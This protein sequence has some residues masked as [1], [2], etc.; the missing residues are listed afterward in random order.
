MEEVNCLICGC[1]RR[2]VVYKGKDRLLELP[3]E[4]LLVRCANCGLVYLS[5]RPTLKEIDRYYP[6]EYEPYAVRSKLSSPLHRW[7]INYGIR[8]RCLP[9]VRRKEGGRVLDIG[10]AI[11]LFLNGMRRYGWQVQG[12]ETNPTAARYAQQ[13]LGLDV[14][15]G[16]LKEAN[17][18]NQYFDAVTMWDVLEHLHDPMTTL[19]EMH[20]VL[21]DDGLLLLRVPNLDSL[22][23]HLFGRYWAGLDVPR[24]MAVFS[25]QTLRQLLN[26]AGFN[27]LRAW[28]LSGSYPVFVLSLR[29]FFKEWVMN[30]RWRDALARVMESWPARLAS[31]PL[32][33]LLDRLNQGPLITVLAEK[34]RQKHA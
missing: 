23:A 19:R 24:H 11:G 13:E 14:F 28:C 5:P 34:Q 22:Q 4:F 27:I 6:L 12:V 10:C 31:I 29:L 17:F 32:F 15:I 9:L 18:P 26:E 8:K 1:K 30:P 3:G 20:R 7:A 16:T 33:W 25:K 21:K 2:S